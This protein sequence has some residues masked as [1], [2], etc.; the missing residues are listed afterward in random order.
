MKFA[1]VLAIL[2]S[3]VGCLPSL[4]LSQTTSEPSI[5]PIGNLEAGNLQIS[6]LQISNRATGPHIE[7]ALVS[8]HNA[9]QKGQTNWIGIVLSPEH[10]WHTYW[11]NPG[12]SGEP[13][14]ATWRSNA[15]LTFGEFLWPVPKQ[16]PVAHLVNYGYEGQNLLMLPLTVS[17]AVQAGEQVQITSELS[18]L[19][20]KEDCIP[21]WATLT[22]TMPVAENEIDQ[23]TPSQY[24][25]LFAQ[26]RQQLPNAEKLSGKHEITESHLTVAYQ[27]PYQSTWQL[28]PL[29]SDV[30]QHN[31][32]QTQLTEG[33]STT[34]VIAL[35]DYFIAA[36]DDLQFL[37][38]DGK[39][40]YYLASQLNAGMLTNISTEPELS[41]ALILIMAF[42]G[43]LILNIMP[44]VLPVLSFKALS[45]SQQSM[46]VGQKLGYALGVLVS[47]N[48]FAL[49]ILM[50]KQGGEAVGWGFH[51]Q[52]PMVI[53][54]L[55]FLFLFIAL[56]LMD[57]GPSGSRFA[58][59][60]QSLVAGNGVS[61]QFFTGILAVVVASPC[62]APFMAAALGVALVSPP[63]ITFAI[64]NALALGFAL[65]LTLI[66]ISQRCKA[67]IPKPGP[68]MNTFKQFLIFPMLATV[69]W[70]LW[71]Y[72][73]QTNAL[74]QFTLLLAL[75][76]FAMLFWL[77]S[78][79][80]GGKSSVAV[81][82]ALM[83][84]GSNIMFTQQ[85]Q[86]SN[87][88]KQSQD[89]FSQEKL[90]A[91]RNSKQVVLVNMTAD[92]CITC[93]VNE[94][95]AFNDDALQSLLN[96]QNV[97]Y[98]VGDWTNKNDSI[99]NFLQQYQRS[100]V[101]LYVVYAGN[102]YETVLPQI[103]TADMVINALNKAKE[104]LSYD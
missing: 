25:E 28:L 2:L 67:F 7:V 70:L 100:G 13:P 71:V 32:N 96:Q 55:A 11:Q 77:S 20:C 64:F 18:W 54:C 95:V 57:I 79:L 84:A 46:S 47:F 33:E 101:P 24:A 37:L 56:V 58:G 10:E 16:I 19:V 99:L 1:R 61:S 94:Q 36:N 83:L 9:L 50:L 42:V 68:W 73:G 72:V 74:A 82:L 102:K 104:E 76:G 69:M 80:Q 98:L 66:F 90:Q 41:I 34:N 63:V 48:V 4:A 52:E 5:P 45:I 91:L 43:G 44:C 49:L 22:L 40:G 17:N 15:D 86:S 87:T 85:G 21:G 8:E 29:R 51:M 78:K 93:K 30:I 92:W 38:T 81:L 103:L 88:V 39:Q 97:H 6:N 3:F 14:A 59:I 75:L 12:D 65:P 53:A 35:S 23:P 60:G 31:Q 27:A 26:T 89:A 62:T